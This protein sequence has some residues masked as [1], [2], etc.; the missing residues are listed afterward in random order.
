ME[1]FNADERYLGE[2]NNKP[3]K[4]AIDLISKINVTESKNDQSLKLNASQLMEFMSN[5]VVPVCLENSNDDVGIVVV[6]SDE[7]NSYRTIHNE[8]T[9][10]EYE[11]NRSVFPSNALFRVTKLHDINKENVFGLSVNSMI[12]LLVKGMQEIIEKID[13]C[14]KQD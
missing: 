4:T 8:I 9:R 2:L 13:N 14:E 11:Q 7:E 5:Y 6:P 10:K 1:G 12:A 3:S